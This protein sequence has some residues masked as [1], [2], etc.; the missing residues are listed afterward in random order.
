MRDYSFSFNGDVD[1]VKVN[2]INLVTRTD[3]FIN[4]WRLL[5]GWNECMI[6]HSKFNHLN[7]CLRE[8]LYDPKWFTRDRQVSSKKINLINKVHTYSIIW[9][10]V[11]LNCGCTTE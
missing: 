9:Q 11:S 8:S 4:F 7:K 2:R 6:I 10:H 1:G 3:M 5:K